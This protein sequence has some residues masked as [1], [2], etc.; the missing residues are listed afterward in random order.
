MEAFSSNNKPLDQQPPQE[1]IAYVPQ[2]EAQSVQIE[3]IDDNTR[4][5]LL[6]K[7]LREFILSRTVFEPV[8]ASNTELVANTEHDD[9]NPSIILSID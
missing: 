9:T 8:I 6:G 3:E 2:P 4:Q 1:T 5:A 7:G